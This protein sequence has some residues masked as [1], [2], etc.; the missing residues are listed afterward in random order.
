M[1]QGKTGPTVPYATS[2][3]ITKSP[4]EAI[5]NGTEKNLDVFEAKR[6]RYGIA[7]FW[8]SACSHWSELADDSIWNA[9]IRLRRA[10]FTF[11]LRPNEF[12]KQRG[13]DN[14]GAF[15]VLFTL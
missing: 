3:L 7:Q 10:G 13:P 8:V 9:P 11:L 5:G 14:F 6:R 12:T 4:Q 15:Y 1:R 2:R